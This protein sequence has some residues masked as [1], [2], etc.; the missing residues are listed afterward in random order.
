MSFT[1]VTQYFNLFFLFFFS[2]F[3]LFLKVILYTKLANF[4]YQSET[5]IAKPFFLNFNYCFPFFSSILSR[6]MCKSR[7][8]LRNATIYPHVT[9]HMSHV[10][11]MDK[12]TELLGGRLLSTG[13]TPSS[14][15]LIITMSSEMMAHVQHTI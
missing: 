13:P 5:A 12:V 8:K 15:S 2:F 14:L 6:N 10:K 9:C 3:E 1:F 4:F 7:Y 11:K